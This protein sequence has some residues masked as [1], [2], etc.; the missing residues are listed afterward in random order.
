MNNPKVANK[1]LVI[2]GNGFDLNL[3]MKSRFSD[4]AASEY[5]KE[6]LQQNGWKN[7]RP[8]WYNFEENMA[9]NYTSAL[10]KKVRGEKER[11][12]SS[13]LHEFGYYL[14][15]YENISE[16]LTEYLEIAQDK[17]FSGQNEI[18]S[19]KKA[20]PFKHIQTIPDIMPKVAEKLKEADAVLS[21]NYT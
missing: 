4:F 16:K 10:L 2:L 1:K 12:K 3:R 8:Y 13:H 17:V 6:I 11:A 20:H 14:K 15:Q 21:F 9:Q 18:L 7:P 19:R 5:G